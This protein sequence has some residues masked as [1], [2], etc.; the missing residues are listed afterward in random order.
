MGWVCNMEIMRIYAISM[1]IFAICLIL[2]LIINTVIF[3][4]LKLPSKNISSS[5]RNKI[6]YLL[7]IN[8]TSINNIFKVIDDVWE[9]E[10]IFPHDRPYNYVLSEDRE[11]NAAL[12]LAT[13]PLQYI[14]DLEKD[15]CKSFAYIQKLLILSGIRD[16][17][18]T[19]PGTVFYIRYSDVY[20]K[21][22]GSDRRFDYA[23]ADVKLKDGTIIDGIVLPHKPMRDDNSWYIF[24]DKNRLRHM[25]CDE[26]MFNT[27][28]IMLTFEAAMMT[29]YYGLL[30]DEKYNITRVLEEVSSICVLIKGLEDA[31]KRHKLR[32]F[33]DITSDKVL[34]KVF[35]SIGWAK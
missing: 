31:M 6:K 1:T 28:I 22:R 12:K 23:W 10:S 16:K 18:I 20:F 19:Y 34:D 33:T 32:S 8:I 14:P 4:D 17:N 2:I 3:M 24:Y 11:I 30:G 7:R 27:M 29:K 9:V 5:I 26:Y 25:S 35:K 21:S 15:E 13:A